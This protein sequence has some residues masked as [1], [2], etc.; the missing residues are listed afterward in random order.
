MNSSLD[1]NGFMVAIVHSSWNGM[2]E[3][4]ANPK[5]GSANSA[6]DA[7]AFRFGMVVRKIYIRLMS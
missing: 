4:K 5:I 6:N 3:W 2:W 7:F 1:F